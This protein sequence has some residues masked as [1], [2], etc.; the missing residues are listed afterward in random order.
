[1]KKHINKICCVLLIVVFASA[2]LITAY[3]HPGRTDSAGGHYNRSTGKYHYHHGYSAH[4][5]TNGECP[6]DSNYNK[7]NNSDT[8]NST[9]FDNNTP[10]KTI[11]NDATDE[12][13]L[14]K[15]TILIV[16]I[17]LAVALFLIVDNR[18]QKHK[19]SKE[20]QKK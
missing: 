4:Q 14:L 1:M 12:H 2:L 11:S 8:N 19:T 17:A 5:H 3:A 10:N 9:T 6:Y 7:K 18:Y 15:T 16:G 20:K 13:Y